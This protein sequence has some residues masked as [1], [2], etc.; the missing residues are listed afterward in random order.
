VTDT[1]G[2][3]T[4]LG[5]WTIVPGKDITFASGTALRRD[6]IASVQIT[7]GDTPILQLR[8]G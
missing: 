3:T 4:P 1:S 5:T 8:T 6:Q 2:A 7:V